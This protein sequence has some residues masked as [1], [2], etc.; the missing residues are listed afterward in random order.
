MHVTSQSPRQRTTVCL[1]SFHPLLT[2]EFERVLAEEEFRLLFRRVQPDLVEDPEKLPIPRASV[3]VAEAHRRQDVTEALVEVVRRRAGT[4][5]L[6]IAEKFTEANAFPLLKIGAKGLLAYSDVPAQLSRALRVIA[7]AGFWVPR[8]LLSR[9]VDTT[10]SSSR[11]VRPLPMIRRLSR[12]E[13]EVM[14]LLLDNLSN[15]EIAR[16]LHFSAR[17]AKFHVSNLLAK[18]GVRRRADLILLAHTQRPETPA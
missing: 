17:T 13:R 3:Y 15:K 8:T 16:E 1:F 4:R 12:R 9:F 11:R 7:E 10:L 5:L 18:H 6:V 2:T 14:E